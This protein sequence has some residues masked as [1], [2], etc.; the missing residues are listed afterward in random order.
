MFLT[1][2]VA[3]ALG[4]SFIIYPVEALKIFAYFFGIIIIL[5]GFA[6]IKGSFKVKRIEKNYEKMKEDIKS[7][8]E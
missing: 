6:Y 7:K 8:F 4:V 2:A 3:I 5:F 1:G